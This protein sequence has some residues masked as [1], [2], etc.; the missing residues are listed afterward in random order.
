MEIHFIGRRYHLI[1]Q[2]IDYKCLQCWCSSESKIIKIHW[3]RKLNFGLFHRPKKDGKYCPSRSFVLWIARVWIAQ[4][5]NFVYYIICFFSLYSLC[6]GIFL[7]KRKIRCYARY[8]LSRI[9]QP[10][11]FTHLNLTRKKCFTF[12]IEDFFHHFGLKKSSRKTE[13]VYLTFP[14]SASIPF[15]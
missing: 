10:L 2:S 15:D 11:K 4:F 12:Y 1:A 3:M 5:L 14:K 9:Q 13:R 6:L 8:W 7:I